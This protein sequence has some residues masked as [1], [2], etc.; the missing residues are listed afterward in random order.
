MKLSRVKK[1][2]E[3]K[4]AEANLVTHDSG[5]AELASEKL[6]EAFIPGA[7]AHVPPISCFL[8]LPGLATFFPLLL[9]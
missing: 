1:G 8:L 7:A 2:G 6:K 4:K 5:K 3:E 9:L